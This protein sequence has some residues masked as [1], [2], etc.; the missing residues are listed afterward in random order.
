MADA[1]VKGFNTMLL[2][3]R[4]VFNPRFSLF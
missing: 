1:Q 2:L 4:T 3:Q